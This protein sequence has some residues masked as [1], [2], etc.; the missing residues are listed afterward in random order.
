MFLVGGKILPAEG[1]VYSHYLTILHL[2]QIGIPYETIMEMED[3]EIDMILGISA[4]INEKQQEQ[5]NGR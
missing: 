4:A 1:F 3:T 5:L 2:L